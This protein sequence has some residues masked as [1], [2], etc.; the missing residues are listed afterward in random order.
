MIRVKVRYVF[1]KSRNHEGLKETQRNADR[2]SFPRYR[3]YWSE[4]SPIGIS[5]YCDT[6]MLQVTVTALRSD[7]RDV[8]GTTYKSS[9]S[10]LATD[11]ENQFPSRVEER[12]DSNWVRAF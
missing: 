5:L 11:I 10:Q 1:N 8:K 6:N 12:D 9:I 4:A 3:S 2:D 7:R